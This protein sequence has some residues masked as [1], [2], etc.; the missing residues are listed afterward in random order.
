MS[1]KSALI[2]KDELLL[3]FYMA[4]NDKDQDK[5]INIL[6]SE[7]SSDFLQEFN[8]TYFTDEYKVSSNLWT[9]A[10]KE[11]KQYG[12]CGDICDEVVYEESH[13]RFDSTR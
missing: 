6:S 1:L 3:T 12:A 4:T 10:G 9:K 7:A 2:T 5:A 13:K 11:C 8:Q